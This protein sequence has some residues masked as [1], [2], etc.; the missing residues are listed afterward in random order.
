[1]TKEATAWLV[2]N[3]ISS[4]SPQT[5]IMLMDIADQV[6]KAAKK[7]KTASPEVKAEL[8]K[9]ASNLLDVAITGG[10][11]QGG[12]IDKLKRLLGNPPPGWTNAIVL[13]KPE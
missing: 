11:H 8:K 6:A 3:G 10:A 4:F 5:S 7:D 9:Y 1:M 13:D 12:V 2:D